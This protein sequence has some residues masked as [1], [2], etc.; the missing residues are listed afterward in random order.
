MAMSGSWGQI[1]AEVSG[2]S[3]PMLWLIFEVTGVEL[4]NKNIIMTWA[5]FPDPDNIG[6]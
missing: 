1:S 5:S 2:K 3:V 6:L 4:A